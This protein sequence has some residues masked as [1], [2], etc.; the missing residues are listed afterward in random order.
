MS[1]P[2]APTAPTTEPS[3]SI[4][5]DELLLALKALPAADLFKLMK[6]AITEAE[7]KSKQLASRKETA[8]KAPK[9]LG[10]MP[11]GPVP[12]QLKK[13]R[14]WVDFT[15]KH[16]RENGWESFTIVHHIKDKETKTIISEEQITMPASILHNGSHIYEDSINEKTPAGRQMISKE[17]M[18][19]SKQRKEAAHATYA[20]FE[21]QY[22]AEDSDDTKSETSATTSSTTAS[23]TVVKKTA[24]EKEAEK[25]Q[26]AAEKAA[27]KERKQQEKAEEKATKAAEKEAEKEKKRLEKEAEK[28][29]KAAAKSS[30]G[31]DSE[32]S[33]TATTAAAPQ[34]AKKVVVKK[35]P[36]NATV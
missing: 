6:T 17:A 36:V 15:L 5:M 24:A 30:K 11:K 25:A 10:S 16:A 4:P 2:T 34:P 3:T 14:A 8:A 22:E 33:A 23:K 12:A 32:S 19:L 18:S 21:A 31:S 27:E 7:K 35:K 26:K 9:K 29:Q 20:E 1:A 13:P 28:A